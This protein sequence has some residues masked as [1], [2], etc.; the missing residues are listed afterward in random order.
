[1][2][3]EHIISLI[4]DNSI[5]SL[6]EANLQMIQVHIRECEDCLHA[7]QAARVSH[8]LL[9]ERVAAEFEP[10]PFFHTRVLATLRERQ[11]ASESWSFVR[12]WKATGVLASSMI[13]TLATLAVLTVAL[14]ERQVSS[15]NVYSAEEVILNQVSQAEEESDVQ[16]LTTI[17]G[18]DEEPSR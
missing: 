1:M 13:A 4:E 16:L 12:L 11:A 8:S 6:N 2:K 3:N 15:Q 18:A 10:S 14:P 17:Y 9:K 5:G 7:F